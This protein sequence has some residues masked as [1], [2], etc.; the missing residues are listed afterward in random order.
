MGIQNKKQKKEFHFNSL[1][2]KIVC[3][4][5]CGILCLAIFLSG[6]NITISKR[7]FVDNFAESQR[8]I[9]NQ[10]DSDFY[11]FYQ[12]ITDIISFISKSEYVDTYFTK[13][14]T[15]EVAEMNNRYR[16]NKQL[17]GSEIANYSQMS[18]FLLGKNGKSFMCSKSDLFSTSKENIL[19]SKIAETAEKNSNK[20]VCIY[21]KKGF[22]NVT[23][24]TPVVIMAKSLSF[25]QNGKTDA[26]VFITIKEADIKRMYKHFTSNTSNIVLLNQDNQVISS[27]NEEFLKSTSSSLK[28]MN[29]LVQA[30]EKEGVL[31][32]DIKKGSSIETY[33]IQ[34]LQSTNY[35]MVGIINPD[36]AFKEKYNISDLVLLTLLL[37]WVLVIFIF[38]F[39]R[40]QTKP[41]AILVDT[42]KNSKEK[43][44]KEHVPIEG[45][46]EVQELSKTYNKMVD[47]LDRYIEQLIQIEEDKRAAEIHALQM[48]INPHYMYNTLASI[49][50]LIWQQDVEKSTKVI[51]AFISL[52]RNVISNSDEFVTIEQEMIN[53]NHYSLINQARYGDSIHVEFFVL[54]QCMEY[55]VP[56][57]ILQ[58]FVENAFFHGFPD[59]MEGTI[60]VFL[61]EEGDNLR[62]D[63]VDNGV[64]IKTE[65]LLAIHKKGAKKSEHFT[66]IGIEN[67]DER[68]KLIYGMDYGINISSKEGK[69][70]KVTLIVP[71]RK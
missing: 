46:Y 11:K 66:G 14:Q 52:L 13:E 29:Q 3:T 53:L 50:W 41:L 19:T 43:K 16:L 59:G 64:G 60:Q 1:L 18:V 63:I 49:K 12:D 58:P 24:S 65:Q 67:V 27:N 32:K 57:L 7:V 4:V 21:E 25:H 68:I 40:Q 45:T 42:M 26:F 17:K 36:E 22:T 54:P 8:K 51:D 44:F 62:F 33:M 31:K 38:V 56:K 30:M 70:T 55:K 47:E 71:K 10:I 37:T 6:L 34:Q 39:I 9:F 61:K 35:K 2:F 20:I 28:K 15:D 23:K 69:G 5:I 48:Q